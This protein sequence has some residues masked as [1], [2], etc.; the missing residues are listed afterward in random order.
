MIFQDEGIHID[1]Q[2]ASVK[3]GKWKED[4][5]HHLEP[6]ITGQRAKLQGVHSA[7]NW[8]TEYASR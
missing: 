1:R 5:S 4:E 7:G 8:P 3:G 2:S 6:E